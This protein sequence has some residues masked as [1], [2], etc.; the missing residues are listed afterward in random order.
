VKA[1]RVVGCSAMQPEKI[2]ISNAAAHSLM[3]R[4]APPRSPAKA[5]LLSAALTRISAYLASRTAIHRLADST[6]A[7]KGTPADAIG[8]A[9]GSAFQEAINEG[10][11]LH[12]KVYLLRGVGIVQ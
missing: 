1:P 6:S 4:D 10:I 7:R 11:S 2:I 8:V 3:I 5:R 12:D 9:F